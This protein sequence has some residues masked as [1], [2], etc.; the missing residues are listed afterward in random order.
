MGGFENMKNLKKFLAVLLAVAVMATMIVPVFANS[1]ISEDAKLVSDL[2]VLKGD[3]SGVDA[4]YLAKGTTRLQAAILYLRLIGKENDALNYSGTEKFADQNKL[5]WVQGR[6]ILSYLKANPTLG[7]AG[8]TDGTFRPNDAITA[9]MLYKVMLE[10]LGFKQG[11]DFEWKDVISFAA[12]KG[13]SKIANVLNVTND[14]VATALVETLKATTKDGKVLVE[15]LIAEGRL[16]A[17][18]A[19]VL[20][21]VKAVSFSAIASNKI[22]VKFNK[23]VDT[24]KAVFEVKYGSIVTNIKSVTWNENKTE[25]TL[26]G[27]VDFAAGDYSINVKGFDKVISG[28][29]KYQT[30]KVVKI[31]ILD[32]IAI[33]KAEGSQEA[34]V[35]FKITDQY[36]QDAT[37]VFGPSLNKSTTA[38]DASTPI[39]IT[40]NVIT[41]KWS[42]SPAKDS[43]VIV[44]LIDQTT[45]TVGTKTLRVAPPSQAGKIQLSA[46]KNKDNKVLRTNTNLAVDKFA[47]DVIATDQ[48]GKEVKNATQLDNDYMVVAPSGLT[49]TWISGTAS[50]PAKLELAAVPN[51]AGTYTLTI[52]SKSTGDSAIANITVKAPLTL[53]T[54]TLQQPSDMYIIGED[55]YIPFVAVD[56]EGNT[57]TKYSDI[58]SKVSLSSTDT[59]KYPV[60][61]ESD[62]I[63]GIAKIKLSTGTGANANDTV[64]VT[65]TV[66][67]NG[68][69]STVTLKLNA[70]AVPTRITG[71]KNAVTKMTVGAS[72]ALAI[73]NFVIKDQYERDMAALPTGY[74]IVL[75]TSDSSKVSVS[76]LTLTGAAVGTSTITAY[77][78]DGTNNI[79]TSAYQFTAETVNKANIASYVIETA[80]DKVFLN[81]TAYSSATPEQ[82]AYAVAYEVYGKTASGDKVG[83]KASD[84]INVTSTNTKVFLTTDNKIYAS[85]TLSGSTTEENATL[86]AMINGANGIVTV[87]KN[88][89]LTN[90]APIGGSVAVK[91]V[92][93]DY[94]AFDN[95]VVAMSASKVNGMNGKIVSSH[96]QYN[97]PSDRASVYFEILDQYGVASASVSPVYYVLTATKVSGSTANY[98]IDSSD[99]RLTISNATSGDKVEITCVTADG[100]TAKITIL[101]K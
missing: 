34:T 26:E 99:G 27:F 6:N 46:L 70:K 38:N 64:M 69:T 14:N 101:V 8:Y 18:K 100:K 93:S 5:T 22:L 35:P 63:S 20:V 91:A 21:E 71:I 41:L 53:D 89:T 80:K 43:L 85:G 23:A 29:V 37:S 1:S 13:L 33:L 54:V 48:Y 86:I 50:Q 4:T 30:R 31:E 92:A 15:K 11:V 57:V 32:D 66:T 83:L 88:V 60:A 12:S 3:G 52:V 2:G 44:T 78:N 75:T 68:K 55:L 61:L 17:N 81:N 84:I 58:V 96:A 97:D 7:W 49:T 10:G 39:S 42:S 19:S 67:A 74:A 9:Q 79:A 51:T 28:V 90:V 87:T 72:S 82:K 62:P 65:A 56:Q 45:G 73:S 77:V 95:N 16:D 24:S 98:S 47:F 76:G 59:A 36:G 40:G 94:Q 25:A